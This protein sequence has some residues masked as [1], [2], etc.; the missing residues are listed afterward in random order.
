VRVDQFVP[1]FAQHDAISN[2]VRQV[3]R[4][5]Q[6][7]GFDSEIFHWELEP[8]VTGESV[9]YTDYRSDAEG[10][11]IYHGSTDSPMAGWLAQWPG[12]PDRLALDYHNIT[13]VRFF[14]RWQLPAAQSMHRARRQLARLAVHT[15]LGL[16]DSPFNQ[17]ELIELGYHPTAVCPILVDLDEYHRDP[18]P[19]TVDKLRGSGRRWLFVGRIAPNKCQHD[20]I[21]AF[22][23]YRRLFDPAATL[24]LI[25]GLI[26]LDYKHA[27]E[28]LAVELGVEA[29]VDFRD[30]VAFT[31]LLAHYRAADVFVCLSEHEGFC[32]P[33]LEAM[34]L[35]VPVVAF[36]STAVTDTVSSAGVLLEDKDPVAVA[37]AVDELLSDEGR[38][39]ALV[40]SGRA[41]ANAFS[42]PATSK[43][44]LDSLSS[45]LGAA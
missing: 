40:E 32:V 42:L 22:A 10:V 37:C 9:P 26:S 44:F 8:R 24:G 12:G 11:I 23:V 35:E 18:D 27:L 3:R 33:I 41:R 25:G 5:L 21:A 43:Q 13:P 16:A 4:L 30:S 38:R 19:R 17:A 15:G 6:G 36:S 28:R 31:E 7:A 34:E 14:A 29:A 1:S 39:A 45:W 20:V 2:H